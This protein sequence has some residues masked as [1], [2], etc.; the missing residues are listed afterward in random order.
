MTTLKTL[1]MIIAL[2][3]ACL[4]IAQDESRRLDLLEF[5]VNTLET[6]TKALSDNSSQI[7]TMT[8]KLEQLRTDL[9]E[10]VVSQEKANNRVWQYLIGPIIL[11]VIQVW[12]IPRLVAK[13]VDNHMAKKE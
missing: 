13:Q 12:F 6:Q 10:Y 9:N 3:V 2:S 1:L 4:S 5:R 8:L 11:G 7:L